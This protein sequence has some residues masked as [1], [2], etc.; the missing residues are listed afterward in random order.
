MARARTAKHPKLEAPEA[1][2]PVTKTAAIKAALA[3]GKESPG[4]GVAFVKERF[5][6]EISPTHFSATKSQLN[7]KAGGVPR[8]RGRAATW[9]AA[10]PAAQAHA[11]NGEADL[12]SAM[13]AIKPLVASMGADKVKRLVDLLG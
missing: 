10:A 1:E 12:I 13:E 4:D 6:I 11:K 2:K 7:K 5:G 3:A 9:P 8:K